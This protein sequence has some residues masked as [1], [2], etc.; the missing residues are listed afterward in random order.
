[1][2]SAPGDRLRTMRRD[3]CSQPTSSLLL[4]LQSRTAVR[5]VYSPPTALFQGAALGQQWDSPL[6]DFRGTPAT[7]RALSQE[8][9]FLCA[10]RPLGPEVNARQRDAPSGVFVL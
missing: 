7:V 1:M 10:A 9:G 3:R 8:N 2:R 4:H 6:L 5:M